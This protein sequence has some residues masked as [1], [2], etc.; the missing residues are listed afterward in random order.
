MHRSWFAV[1]PCY[2][3]KVAG[4]WW[5]KTASMGGSNHVCSI[6]SLAIL[7]SGIQNDLSRPAGK[8]LTWQEHRQWTDQQ[9]ET[10]IALLVLK[11]AWRS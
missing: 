7:R 3:G 1:C 11:A 5:S 10:A 4:A 6:F 9:V 2:R 8:N